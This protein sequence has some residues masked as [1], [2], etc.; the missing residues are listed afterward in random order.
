[1]CGG[2]CFSSNSTRES[3]ASLH[4]CHYNFCSTSVGLM[5]LWLSL[6]GVFSRG[7]KPDLY[8]LLFSI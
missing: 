1:M 6:R 4:F 2:S 8:L 5:P 7:R 3:F